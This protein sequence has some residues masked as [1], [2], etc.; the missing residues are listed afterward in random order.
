MTTLRRC[1]RWWLA[2]FVLAGAG[3]LSGCMN[4]A[5]DPWLG[6]RRPREGAERYLAARPDLSDVDKH[7]LLDMQPIAPALLAELARSS[8]REVRAYVAMNPATPADTLAMLAAD[9][10]V[11]VRQYLAPHPR[12]PRPQLQQLLADPSPLVRGAALASPSWS[13]E[14]LWTLHRQG[15]DRA[16]IAR[17]PNA[18]AELLMALTHGPPSPMLS[19]QLARSPQLTPEIEAFVLAQREAGSTAKLT[20]LDNP[21]LSCPT[22]E[23]LAG[24]PDPQ[25]A[26]R[27]Q[28]H[29]GPDQG[30][31]QRCRAKDGP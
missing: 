3:A 24:D 21:R 30:P 11:G 19:Y 5:F 2:G 16:A 20:L 28:R 17:N 6:P 4:D 14:A 12:L 23:R 27:A 25:V 9:P 10:D 26:Q 31:G 29:L 15:H 18:P 7:R 13:A 22:L 1:G 8:P